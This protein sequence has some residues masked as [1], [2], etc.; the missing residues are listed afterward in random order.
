MSGQNKTWLEYCNAVALIK[1]NITTDFFS[2]CL[3]VQLYIEYMQ[4]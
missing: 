2:W 3:H 1:K 4:I